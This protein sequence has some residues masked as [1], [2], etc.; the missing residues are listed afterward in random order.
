M[1]KRL[2]LKKWQKAG[3]ILAFAYFI[4]R[5]M[6]KLGIIE[7]PVV[8][9]AKKHLALWDGLYET[10]QEVIELMHRYWN[11]G[12]WTWVDLDEIDQYDNEYAW[13]CAFIVS[14][15]KQSGAGLRFPTTVKHAV[16][17]LKAIENKAL[18][19]G[20]IIGHR[21]GEYTPKIGDIIV[22]ERSNYYGGYDGL[23]EDSKTHG[24]IIVRED[25]L[26]Y[27]VIGGNVS[28]TVME[29]TVPKASLNYSNRWFAV[30][31]NRIF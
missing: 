20:S 26:N 21:I 28:N 8:A 31:E 1:V 23:E 22:K 5:I 14:M 18:G 29:T 11:D 30:I 19:M 7:P 6:G 17:T 24:D 4:Y 3:L 2:N 13:S 12:G 27:Y 16:Y 9:M 10:D 25:Q 15:F